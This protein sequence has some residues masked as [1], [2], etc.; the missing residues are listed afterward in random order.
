MLNAY[1]VVSH[2]KGSWKWQDRFALVRYELG[3]LRG[4][5]PVWKRAGEING[6]VT[7]GYR[8]QLLQNGYLGHPVYD[9]SLHNMPVPF[10]GEVQQ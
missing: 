4:G 7:P 5:R 3:T 2:Q 1:A 9:G 6:K 10:A 8:R